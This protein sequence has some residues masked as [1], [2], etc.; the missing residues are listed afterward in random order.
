MTTTTSRRA[1]LAGIAA[2]PA[3]AAPIVAAITTPALGGA[4]RDH[5]FAVIEEH[6]RAYGVF[7]QA[8]HAENKA[9]GKWMDETGASGTAILPFKGA[10]VE[11]LEMIGEGLGRLIDLRVATGKDCD[12]L[13]PPNQFPADN[14]KLRARLAERKRVYRKTCGPSIAARKAASDIKETAAWNLRAWPPSSVAGV[15]AVLAYLREHYQLTGAAMFEEEQVGT[16]LACL[17]E[18]MCEIAGLPEPMIEADYCE[19]DIVA[20]RQEEAA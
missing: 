18:T 20:Q 15:A 17:E 8:V 7:S 6:R 9:E 3:L 4:D 13:A 2:A 14:S 5:V 16:F 11:E 12:R 10:K 1:V 19:I